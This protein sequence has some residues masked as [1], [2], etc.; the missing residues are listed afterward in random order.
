[1]SLGI[2]YHGNYC[3]PGW[4]DGKYQP[5]VVGTTPAVDDF[6]LT[7]QIHDAA[8]ATG[9]DLVAA[10]LTFAGVNLTTAAGTGDPKRFIAGAAVGLQGLGR[11][12]SGP[13]T[14]ALD[15]ISTELATTIL[16]YV[17]GPSL[18]AAIGTKEQKQLVQEVMAP[19]R[20]K[21][22]PNLP[23]LT[24]EERARL[25]R[26]KQELSTLN[27]A[28]PTP[29]LKQKSR[30]L[31]PIG[32]S[33]AVATPP[34]SIGTSVRSTKPATRPTKDG[35]ILQGR[36][37]LSPVTQVANANWQLSAE[38]PLHPMYYANSTFGNIARS[39]QFY[40]WRRL[41]IH[42]ITKVPTSTD[43]EIAIVYAASIT[44]PAENGAAA[45]FLPRVMTRGNA[46][47]GPIW[48]NHSIEVDCDNEFRLIDP[49]V[50]PDI[51]K[52]VFGELQ[53]YTNCATLSETVGYLLIDYDVEFKTTMFSPHSSLLPLSGGVLQGI[54]I[55]D[56]SA[57]PTTPNM[58]QCTNSSITALTSGTVFKIII[59]ASASTPA[60]GT[61]LANAWQTS[62]EYNASTTTEQTLVTSLTITDGMAVYGVVV[63]SVMLLYCSL[64]A[65]LAG[66]ASGQIFYATSGTSRAV[67]ACNAYLV[68][69]APSVVTNTQ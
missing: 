24:K 6:D 9:A 69:F 45:S 3:G 17:F 1:M 66:S 27:N 62:V 43:G 4:S 56:F 57:T 58:V 7:C 25:E 33:L 29:N 26:F 48:Q 11:I 38:A 31:D 51:A 16:D 23:P 49:F 34:V 65:A 30:Y 36:E 28:R 18:K 54:Q 22:K 42:Y 46:M 50:S 10:D 60:T 20:A 2:A 40:R 59:N 53:T 52:H 12:A 44:E 15:N 37:F 13:L 21:N 19:R 8:Y 14:Q 67:W 5:S 35:V 68:Q 61:T 55:T 63:N 47:M 32:P 64:S 41:V 39:Y